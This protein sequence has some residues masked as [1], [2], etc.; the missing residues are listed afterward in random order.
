MTHTNELEALAQEIAATEG[1]SRA[2]ALEVA[3]E[4][5]GEMEQY[6]QGWDAWIAAFAGCCCPTCGARVAQ[7][8][9]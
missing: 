1:I 4:L 8:A 3:R 5:L 2:R 9:A 6:A 7:A